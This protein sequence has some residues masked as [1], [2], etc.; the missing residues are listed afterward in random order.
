MIRTKIKNFTLL[1]PFVAMAV[2]SVMMTVLM[3]FFSSAQKVTLR[4]GT[5]TEIFES[6]RVA[7]ELIARDFKSAYYGG[8][9]ASYFCLQ[10]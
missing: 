4:T 5:R 7:M 2:F 6:G 10:L 8:S 3:Q 9:D 1:E